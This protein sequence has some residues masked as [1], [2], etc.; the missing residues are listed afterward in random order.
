MPSFTRSA[1][2]LTTV[3]SCIP[4]LT[5]AQ[6][7]PFNSTAYEQ[8]QGTFEDYK[9]DRPVNSTGRVTFRFDP[10]LGLS[11]EDYYI[12]LTLE[13]TCRESNQYTTYDREVTHSIQT[14][15]SV[16]ED[17]KGNLCLYHFRAQNASASGTGMDGCEGVLSQKC[18][19]ALLNANV[20]LSLVTEQDG[21]CPLFDVTDSLKEECGS[22]FTTEYVQEPEVTSNC[23]SPKRQYLECMLYA[24]TCSL[25]SCSQ[26][27]QHLRRGMHSQQ[28]GEHVYARRYAYI[29][30]VAK[31]RDRGFH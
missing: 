2:L 27:A 23:K 31:E 13:D 19:D 21:G 11:A 29:F 14:W 8:C 18:H 7:P 17:A 30:D 28:A 12:S 10:I 22:I 5:S 3:L 20:D 25:R 1:A 6:D 24:N 15:L 9:T 26:D 16:P 4:S